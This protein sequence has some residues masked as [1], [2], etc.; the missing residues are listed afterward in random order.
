MRMASFLGIVA[1][2]QTVG[3]G[4]E[5]TENVSS[6][7]V[8]QTPSAVSPQLGRII[9]AAELPGGTWLLSDFDAR[10]V[11][12]FDSISGLGMAGGRIGPG[13]GEYV[14]PAQLWSLRGDS[15]LMVNQLE[16]RWD[17]F[18]GTALHGRLEPVGRPNNVL[19]S[20]DTLGGFVAVRSGQVASD[21][22]LVVYVNRVSGT[23]ATIAR[24]EPPP[25]MH[26]G[27]PPPY[28]AQHDDAAVAPDGWTAIRRGHPYRIDWVRPDGKMIA[29]PPLPVDR[30]PVTSAEREYFLQALSSGRREQLGPDA[31]WPEVVPP[32]MGSPILFSPDGDAVIER[33]ANSRLPGR[34]YDVVGRDGQL[35]FRVEFSRTTRILKFGRR[36]ALLLVEDDDGLVAPSLLDW[37]PPR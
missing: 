17:V 26:P 4:G 11:V 23:E 15:V 31:E 25:A 35:R 2:L 27:L 3:C 13:P 36:H 32:A 14:R 8:E 21:S 12:T 34:V 20:F 22:Q 10:A 33:V 6:T 28:P 9:G 1:A 30:V 5:E 18:I 24:L 7:R 37:P 19:I 16:R 29:G